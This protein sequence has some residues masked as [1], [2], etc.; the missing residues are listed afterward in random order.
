MGKQNNNL[1][2]R[3]VTG[4][5]FTPYSLARKLNAI[6]ILES[7]SFDQGKSRYSILLIKEAFKVVQQKNDIYMEVNGTRKN[8]RSSASDILSILLYFAN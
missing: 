8:I 2:I 1:T 3:T 4:E 7:A 5:R 6:A